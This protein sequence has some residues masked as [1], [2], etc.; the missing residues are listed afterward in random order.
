MSELAAQAKAAGGRAIRL[1]VSG[2]FHSPYMARAT[3]E[4]RAYLVAHPLNRPTIP[5]YANRTALPYGEDREELLAMQT[6]S[7]VRWRETVENMR[8]DGVSR[9]IE[10]GAGTTLCGMIAKTDASLETM[11]VADGASLEASVG[12]LKEAEKC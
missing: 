3:E 4:L 8:E 12:R 7:P 9:F 6:S 1:N 2:A 11:N 10:V 5:V